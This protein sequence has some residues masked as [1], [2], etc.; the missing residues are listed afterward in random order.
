MAVAL[1]GNLS[2]F[3]IGEV[4]Q[5]I[6]Q[7]RKTGLL[8]ADQGGRLL[9]VGFVEGSVVWAAPAG[10]HDDAAFADLL[11]RSGALAPEQL[12]E[13][14]PEL[15]EAGSL[16]RLAAQRARIPVR[17][18]DALEEL[19]T[20][21]T[22]FE[23]LRWSAGSFHFSAQ[24]VRERGERGRRWPAEQILMD[25]LRMVDEWRTLDPDA[26][27]EDAVFRR[28]A[29]FEAYRDSVRGESGDQLA[30]AARLHE[31]ADGQRP[32]RRLFD[33]ARVT[34]FDGARLLTGMRRAGALELAAPGRAVAAVPAAAS[35]PL[36]VAR[37][38]ARAV[39]ALGAALPFAALALVAV[40]AQRAPAPEPAGLELDLLAAARA[41]AAAERV[42]N[43]AEA[44]R[45]LHGRWP[46]EAAELTRDGWPLEESLATPGGDPYVM[47]DAE[48]AGFTALAP[49]S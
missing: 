21:E 39:R 28:G 35:V 9:H 16:R 10:S 44:W 18:L 47:S 37:A 12:V 14:E 30:A 29:P 42:R 17:E 11:V 34:S 46:R 43:A 49:E 8:E 4:F 22:V 7:Q 36:A 13:L 40:L 45:V 41:G 2:D 20:Q 24:K 25:G 33:L 6:G 27:R 23:L 3:G 15:G 19:L 26:R 32:V 38:P 1:R 31:L 5:L 48:G